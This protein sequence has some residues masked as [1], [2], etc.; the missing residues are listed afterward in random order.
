MDAHDSLI[1]AV[2]LKIAPYN[3]GTLFSASG[4]HKDMLFDVWVNSGVYP[5]LGVR[6]SPV[7]SSRVETVTFG[8]VMDLRLKSWN[9]VVLHIY[10]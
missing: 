1:L 5:V 3:Y 7:N 6:Y 8:P 2:Y 4:G 10:R 9:K